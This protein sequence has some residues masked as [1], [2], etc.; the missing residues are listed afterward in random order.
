MS[1]TWQEV[2]EELGGCE[3]SANPC[4]A[5]TRGTHCERCKGPCELEGKCRVCRAAVRIAILEN[6]YVKA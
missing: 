4:A 3:Y 6:H 5:H 1:K 2:V